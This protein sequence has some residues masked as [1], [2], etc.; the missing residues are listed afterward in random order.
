MFGHC[1]R[2]VTAK[3]TGLAFNCNNLINLSME[4]T[5]TA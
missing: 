5:V 2:S 3:V 1:A 4:I